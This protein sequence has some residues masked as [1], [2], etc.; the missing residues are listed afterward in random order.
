MVFGVLR[1][2]AGLPTHEF[3]L[4][5]NNTL[6]RWYGDVEAAIRGGDR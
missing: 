2:L 4:A 1:G 5:Q 6:R 3:V